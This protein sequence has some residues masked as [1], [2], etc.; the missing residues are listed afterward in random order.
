MEAHENSAAGIAVR[1]ERV[2]QASALVLVALVLVGTLVA[3]PTKQSLLSPFP[4]FLHA[5]KLGHVMGF[6]AIGF[7]LVRSRFA[8][9][10]PRHIVA[11][12]LA[13]GA[14]TEFCQGFIPGRT[15][16]LG[17]VL[18]DVAGAFAGVCVAIWRRTDR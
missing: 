9:V 14:L 12:A 4:P 1:P 17:D 6:A 10:G 11:F 3:G 5:D 16:K 18:I 15:G 7:A 13:L 2:A 8:G